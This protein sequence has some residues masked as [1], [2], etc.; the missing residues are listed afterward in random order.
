[1][2]KGSKYVVEDGGERQY[3]F[4]ITKLN[5]TSRKRDTLGKL[6]ELDDHRDVDVIL[7]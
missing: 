7:Q 4:L 1:V 3:T 6:D 2:G 5:N